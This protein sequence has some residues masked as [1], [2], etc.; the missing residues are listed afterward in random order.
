MREAVKANS[1]SAAN[2]DGVSSRLVSTRPRPSRN[3]TAG[4]AVA[5]RRG[6]AVRLHR[7]AHVPVRRRGGGTGPD[8]TD[9]RAITRSTVESERAA[10]GR[11]GRRP[12]GAAPARGG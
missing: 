6:I 8:A 12:G 7:L 2:G 9:R 10:A 5:V 11:A 3:Q 4:N 1:N